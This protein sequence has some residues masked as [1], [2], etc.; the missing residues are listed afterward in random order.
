[1]EW[2]LRRRRRKNDLI[3]LNDPDSVE[4]IPFSFREKLRSACSYNVITMNF[5]PRDELFATACCNSTIVI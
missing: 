2:I 5:S 3:L 1:M 4:L